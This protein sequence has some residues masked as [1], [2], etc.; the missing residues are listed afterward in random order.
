MSWLQDAVLLGQSFR[1]FYFQLGRCDDEDATR[2]EMQFKE[3]KERFLANAACSISFTKDTG[4]VKSMQ[5][6]PS[7]ETLRG[8]MFE[9]FWKVERFYRS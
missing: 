5:Q 3:Y 9:L 7:D 1:E 4:I 2:C 8:A 6:V